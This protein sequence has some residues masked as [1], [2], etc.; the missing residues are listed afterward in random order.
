MFSSFALITPKFYDAIFMFVLC[1][2]FQV[3]DMYNA[4]KHTQGNNQ[5]IDEDE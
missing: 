1:H 5:D 2:Y 4:Q 3:A